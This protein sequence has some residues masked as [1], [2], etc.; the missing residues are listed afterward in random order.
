MQQLMARFLS[1]LGYSIVVAGRTDEAI[2]LARATP[3]LLFVIDMHLPD[4][5]GP[6]ALAAMRHLPGCA[7]T[8]AIAISG[9]DESSIRT[10]LGSGFVAY[11][12]KPIDLDAFE[13]IVA[14]YVGDRRE[15]SV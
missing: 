3:P 13:A 8:P 12:S 1:E 9:M 15:R 4:R 7:A 10:S 6:D 5:D 11:L 14:E 2:E